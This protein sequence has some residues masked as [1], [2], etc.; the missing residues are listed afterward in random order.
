M[1]HYL[2]QSPLSTLMA[3]DDLCD[4]EA[5]RSEKRCF[6]AYLRHV[7]TRMDGTRPDPK[8]SPCSL[9]EAPR[10]L[11]ALENSDDFFDRLLVPK[12]FLYVL[13]RNGS[14]LPQLG[15]YKSMKPVSRTGANTVGCI[16]LFC[17]SAGPSF[18]RFKKARRLQDA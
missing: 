2:F 18:K 13:I 16:S 3:K 14:A 7:V 17:V 1:Q 10:D 4:L 5:I 6:S 11:L 9:S 15:A 8:A 12:N